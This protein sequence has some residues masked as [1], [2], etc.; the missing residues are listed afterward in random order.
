MRSSVDGHLGCF[1]LLTTVNNAAVNIRVQVFV[2]IPVSN[3][4]Q[5]IPGKNKVPIQVTT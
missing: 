4:F 5:Y 1:Y 2:R 3:C